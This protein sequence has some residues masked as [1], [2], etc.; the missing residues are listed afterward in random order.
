MLNRLIEECRRCIE[1]EFEYT[2]RNYHSRS[3]L[4]RDFETYQIFNW[5]RKFLEPANPTEDCPH[6]YG[7]FRK[8]SVPS[9]CGQFVNCVEGRG[10]TFDCP[11]GLAFS[12][13]TYRCDWPDMVA[14]C[15]AEGTYKWFVINAICASIEKFIHFFVFSFLGIL[16]P[17]GNNR[18][19]LRSPTIQKFQIPD[20]LPTLFRVCQWK[21]KIVQL[22][23]RK[24]LQRIDRNMW[25]DRKCDFLRIPVSKKSTGHTNA[26]SPKL[27]PTRQQQLQTEFQLQ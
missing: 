6:Q 17:S 3:F 2:H 8:S 24:R 9:E 14:D 4:Y 20:R 5:N 15:D 22:R 10:Y 12:I 1:I 25:R 23:R 27:Q 18:S 7:Y 26:T 13:D 19:I 11:E 21:T 16:V